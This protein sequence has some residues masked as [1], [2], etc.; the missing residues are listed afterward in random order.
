MSRNDTTPNFKGYILLKLVTQDFIVARL[1]N[2]TKDG[3]DV[4]EPLV[5]ILSDDDESENGAQVNFA[6]MNPF[7]SETRFTLFR[8]GVIF[9][10]GIDEDLAEFYEHNVRSKNSSSS[11]TQYSSDDLEGLLMDIDTDDMTLN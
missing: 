11:P 6:V 4:E 7:T 1:V 2:E 5:M 10:S 3:F 9:T 8:T